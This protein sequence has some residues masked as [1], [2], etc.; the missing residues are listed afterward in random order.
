M[1]SK[2]NENKPSYSI[3]WN[4]HPVVKSRINN[5]VV[6]VTKS[7][8]DSL[9]EGVDLRGKLGYGVGQV[10]IDLTKSN[11]TLYEGTVEIFN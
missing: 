9:F 3:N 5:A 4:A 6:L 7:I 1:K 10:C 11:Y 8:N 2:I